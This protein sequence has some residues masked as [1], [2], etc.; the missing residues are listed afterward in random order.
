[1]TALSVYRDAWLERLREFSSA[2]SIDVEGIIGF[3][4]FYAGDLY[5]PAYDEAVRTGHGERFVE[6]T[7]CLVRSDGKC[8][9]ALRELKVAQSQIRL[10]P[11]DDRS[12]LGDV[13][14]TC[15][16]AGLLDSPE[17]AIYGGYVDPESELAFRKAWSELRDPIGLL[18]DLTIKVSRCDEL[19]GDEPSSTLE[20]N[21]DEFSNQPRRSRRGRRKK[22]DDEADIKFYRDW[23]SSGLTSREFADARRIDRTEADLQIRRG[24]K[25][26]PSRKK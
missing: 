16:E 7:E 21:A 13:E 11:I 20:Q 6:I 4:R 19:S 23:K 2:G 24:E 5:Q 25:K 17:T 8:F 1:M 14:R 26:D 18:D 12:L 9:H 10:E 3:D 15:L 22:Y